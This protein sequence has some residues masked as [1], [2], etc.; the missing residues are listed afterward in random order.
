MRILLVHNSSAGD[1]AHNRDWLETLVRG[2]GHEVQYCAATEDWKSA[3]DD[4]QS[5]LIVAAGGD[6]TVADVARHLA[7]RGVPL[8]V[9]PLGTANNIAGAL[10][11]DSRP[12]PE[13]VAGWTEREPRPFDTGR[14]V[15]QGVHFRFVESVGLGLLAESIAEITEGDAGY[16]DELDAAEA[17]MD[18]A[19]EVLRRTLQQLTP[20]RVELEL[21]GR[22]LAGEYLL[23]E[24]MNF[25][26]AGPNL[27]LAPG[28]IPDDGLF[29][30]VVAEEQ[31]RAALLADLPG[32]RRAQ[33]VVAPLPVYRAAHVKM[34]CERCRLHLD[35]QIQQHSGLLEMTVEPRSL[36]FLA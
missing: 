25:G 21:D 35:D 11:I 31:H 2:A 20:T 22:R 1:T 27:A 18:A 12:A 32:Y 28:A 5:D 17:R 7:G 23:V 15:G 24:I 4:A 16:V 26:R 34:N 14:A 33:A 30:I 36:R 9:L 19:I 10:G 6:G 13:I 29:E 3:I 8:G